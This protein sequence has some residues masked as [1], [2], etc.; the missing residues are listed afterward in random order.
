MTSAEIEWA[1]FRAISCASAP[2]PT[3]AEKIFNGLFGVLLLVLVMRS[4]CGHR[5]APLRRELRMDCVTQL[6]LVL[7]A[8]LVPCG[9]LL[10]E[11]KR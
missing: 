1:S 10:F 11:R 4:G 3:F 2:L 7:V 6:N 5:L 9:S 8:S